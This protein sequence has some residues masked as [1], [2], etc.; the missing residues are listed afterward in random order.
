MSNLTVKSAS[1]FAIDLKPA[2]TIEDQ[3]ENRENQNFAITIAEAG[4]ANNKLVTTLN[5]IINDA[6][7]TLETF[8]RVLETYL[9][10][11]ANTSTIVNID[12]TNVT[13]HYN[14]RSAL[15]FSKKLPTRQ[16]IKVLSLTG[17][18]SWIGTYG[19]VYYELKNSYFNYKNPSQLV[20]T[21]FKRFIEEQER[22]SDSTKLNIL[23]FYQSVEEIADYQLYLSH[24]DYL[25]DFGLFPLITLLDYL[26]DFFK[27]AYFLIETE[28]PDFEYVANLIQVAILTGLGPDTLVDLSYRFIHQDVSPTEIEVLNSVIERIKTLNLDEIKNE[29]V[30]DFLDKAFKKIGIE[31]T[32]DYFTKWSYAILEDLAQPGGFNYLLLQ[33]S[34]LLLNRAYCLTHSTKTDYFT[35]SLED[36][37]NFDEEGLLLISRV[38]RLLYYSGTLLKKSNLINLNVFGNNLCNLLKIEDSPTKI[39]RVLA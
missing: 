4:A 31:K 35:T 26:E 15:G 33:F 17:R 20:N 39:K 11:L 8:N 30:K 16:Y 1:I 32:N 6:P 3:I 29:R 5:D 12:K 10:V 28:V 18:K 19:S 38:A 23:D 21:S 25:R 36:L 13:S 2:I 27:E 37:D 22:L 7:Y 24:L 14:K 9:I 34:V